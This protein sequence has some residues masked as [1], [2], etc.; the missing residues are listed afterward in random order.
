MFGGGRVRLR[1]ISFDHLNRQ[2]FLIA[3]VKLHPLSSSVKYN[4][5]RTRAGFFGREISLASDLI[6]FS[7]S[8]LDQY[9]TAI[10]RPIHD[11]P[12]RER[13]WNCRRRVLSIQSCEDAS[14]CV[15]IISLIR[16]AVKSL[17]KPTSGSPR[18]PSGEAST[19]GI[20]RRS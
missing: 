8:S 2:F 4:H 1:K 15:G 7:F 13:R 19:R 14:R 17:P 16:I 3:F 6:G 12:T 10:D 5:D 20:S 11:I 18:V 9:F